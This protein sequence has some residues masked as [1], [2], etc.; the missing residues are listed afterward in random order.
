MHPKTVAHHVRPPLPPRW[1]W[2]LGQW[3]E[4]APEV[5]VTV[6]YPLTLR[7]SKPSVFLRIMTFYIQ[8][9]NICS[10]PLTKPNASGLNDIQLSSCVLPTAALASPQMEADWNPKTRRSDLIGPIL[11]NFGPGIHSCHLDSFGFIFQSSAS[12]VDSFVLKLVGPTTTAFEKKTSKVWP[13][14]MG[15]LHWRNSQGW[16]RH[17]WTCP[18]W[19][20]I[21]DRFFLKTVFHQI[22]RWNLQGK[23]CLTWMR[24]CLCLCPKMIT[25]LDS[26]L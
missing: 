22:W 11:W 23:R 5:L 16:E 8:Y 15:L 24:W 2:R 21:L 18:S 10:A 26:T 20:V 9:T 6:G 25:K 13:D 19:D 4:A 14:E 1:W 7:S 12:S 3:D 17:A